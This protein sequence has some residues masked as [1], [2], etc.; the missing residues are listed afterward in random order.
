MAI[1]WHKS[2]SEIGF[3]NPN[4]LN[5]L[6]GVFLWF[7]KLWSVWLRITSFLGTCTPRWSPRSKFLAVGEQ[8]LV[9][10]GCLLGELEGES[11]EKHILRCSDKWNAGMC[12]G[13][14][15]SCSTYELTWVGAVAFYSKWSGVMFEQLSLV[16]DHCIFSY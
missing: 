2:N 10:D 4:Y 16:P 15:W 7:L 13:N 1:I 14:S 6:G 11:F 8:L 9:M 12:S 5:L 3:P